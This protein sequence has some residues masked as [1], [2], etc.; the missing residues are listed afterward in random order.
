MNYH[1]IPEEFVFIESTPE[2]WLNVLE[3][4]L[5]TFLG[6]YSE[7]IGDTEERLSTGDGWGWG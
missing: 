5:E 7:E 3:L 6:R 1:S 2:S 4:S